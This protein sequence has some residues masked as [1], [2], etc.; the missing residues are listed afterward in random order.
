MAIAVAMLGAPACSPDDGTSVS[1]D[2]GARR[3]EAEPTRPE[4]QERPARLTDAE[5]PDPAAATA[6]FRCQTLV[7]PEDRGEPS[8]RQVELPVL[9]FGAGDGDP[10]VVLH[11]GPGGGVVDDW[12]LWSTTFQP[13]DAELVLYDQR[14][15]GRSRPRLDCPEHADALLEVLGT[16]APPADERAVVAGA[17]RA[18]HERLRAEGVALDEYDTPTSTRDL[19]ALRTAL[20]AR[21]L[22][23]VASS[24]GTRLALDYLRAHP[25]RVGALVLDGADPPD[26]LADAD[27]A[28]AAD[29]AV[30]RLVDAC[31]QDR[32]CDA[33]HPDLAARLERTLADFDAQPRRVQVDGGD[34]GPVEL[35]IDGDDLYAGLHAALYDSDVI[36]H[37]PA[38]VDA[39]AA[40]GGE[41]LDTVATQVLPALLGTATG[42]FLSVECADAGAPE[43][44]DEDPGRAATIVLAGALAYCDDWAV[45][46]VR[47]EFREPPAVEDPPPVLVVAGELD[48]IT[49]AA[50]SQRVAELLEATYVELPRAGHSPMLFDACATEVLRG[51]LADPDAALPTCAT[52]PTPPP[53]A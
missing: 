3:G 19:E 22:R 52:D 49:P 7:L 43:A 27:A 11:G 53:F 38:M 28:T 44:P 33:A 46:P 12:A 41:L 1:R 37:L 32:A 30:R 45:A 25:E 51:F 16:N 18:C 47:G 2:S 48:P 14:G 6:G 31:E 17:V 36:P 13:D 50:G 39:I 4:E 34:R 26:A 21:R 15:G 20:G 23:L 40:A 8:G 35:S 10:V 9:R 5:C 42:A 24:Y 29:A